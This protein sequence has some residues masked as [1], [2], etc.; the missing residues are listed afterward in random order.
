MLF[1]F[2]L[3]APIPAHE[4]ARGA[5]TLLQLF[6]HR[7]RSHRHGYERRDL[8]PHSYPCCARLRIG[9][10]E[11]IPGVPAR[12][13]TDFI[14]NEGIPACSSERVIDPVQYR[15]HASPRSTAC[16]PIPSAEYESEVTSVKVK[17]DWSEPEVRRCAYQIRGSRGLGRPCIADQHRLRPKDRFAPTGLYQFVHLRSPSWEHAPIIFCRAGARTESHMGDIF[18]FFLSTAE[19]RPTTD[20]LNQIFCTRDRV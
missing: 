10:R 1:S 5:P 2:C 14:Y 4:L 19:R 11:T 6:K 8:G 15:L 16:Q 7:S 12:Y 18:H 9:S 3:R 13:R 17:R 20:R